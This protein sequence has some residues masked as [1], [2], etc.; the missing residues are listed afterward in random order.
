MSRLVCVEILG[1]SRLLNDRMSERL[2][3]VGVSL[4]QVSTLLA[5]YEEDGLTQS[6]LSRIT[7]VEQPTMAVNLKRMERDGLVLR[8]PDRVDR[9]R[10]RVLLTPRARD[11]RER[12]QAERGEMD[13]IALA[14]VPDGDRVILDRALATMNENLAPSA[15]H[16][17]PADDGPAGSY[18]RRERTPHARVPVVRRAGRDQ[19]KG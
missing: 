17:G 12:I 18:T 15:V 7:G 6:E 2:R 16:R 10:A 9:R 1:V 8:V 5:L 13:A 3:E 11:L 4:G 19:T 14:G